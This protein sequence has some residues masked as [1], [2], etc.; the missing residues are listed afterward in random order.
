MIWRYKKIILFLFLYSSW[1][2]FAFAQQPTVKTDSLRIYKDIENVSK[3]SG[4]TR[5]IHSLI[6]KPVDKDAGAVKKV[7]AVSPVSYKP[8]E[9]K[10][11]RHININTSDPFG[12]SLHD[13][14]VTSQNFLYKAGNKLHNKTKPFAIK[15]LLLISENEPFDSLRVNESERL[16]RSRSFVREVA[17]K[18]APAENPDSVDIFIRVIDIWSITPE[19]AFSASRITIDLTDKNFVGIGHEFQNDFTWYRVTGNNIYNISYLIPNIRNTYISASAHYT[20]ERYGN[21]TKSASVDRPFYSPLAKWAGGIY[22]A[23]RFRSDSFYYKDS[24]FVNRTFK[25]NTQDYWAGKSWQIFKGNT[26]DERTTNLILTSRFL[27][28]RFLEKPMEIYDPLQLNS[29]EDFYLA[30]FGIAR[31]KYVKD[32]Y[33]FNYG[34]IEDVP[35]GNL[36]GLTAGYQVKNNTERLYTAA[37]F[38]FGNYNEW[39]YFSC[40]FEYGTFFHASHAEQGVFTAGINYFTRLYKIGNWNL[41]QF[42]KPRLSLGINRFTYE[43]ITINNENGIEGFNSIYLSGNSKIV[44]TLQ[45]QSYSPWNVLGF[46]FGPYLISSFGM[47]GSEASGFKNCRVYSQFALGLLVKNE[48]LVFD[49]FQVSVSFYPVIPG[50][51]VNIFKVNS[52]LTTDFGFRDFILGKPGAIEYQ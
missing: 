41:R 20:T 47:L 12:Y 42:I 13:T 38:S 6:F 10:I 18:V 45:T 44:L 51:G 35:E 28:I 50:E 40:N 39:G 15:S 8:F 52:N 27:R 11:I 5:F 24:A 36:Y 17:F 26:V 7:I 4:F 16:I 48:F 14:S 2:W 49:I 29:N 23:Q 46:R 37:R 1:S 30:G 9:G 32:K 3:K 33:I 25:F 43:S 31:R 19:L 34:I 22:L 21:Y